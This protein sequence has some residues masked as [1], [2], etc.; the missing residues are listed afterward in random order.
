MDAFPRCAGGSRGGAGGGCA[1][2]GGDGAV[3]GPPVRERGPRASIRKRHRERG[4]ARLGSRCSGRALAEAA[5]SEATGILMIR[6]SD[7]IK[8]S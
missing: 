8:L 4:A 7:E 1:Q 3:R 2:D 6:D 5:G